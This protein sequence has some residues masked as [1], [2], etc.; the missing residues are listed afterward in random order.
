M[1]AVIVLIVLIVVIVVIVLFVA[2]YA[3]RE[4]LVGSGHAKMTVTPCTVIQYTDRVARFNHE[5]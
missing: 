4:W 3:G 1:F 2:L 5:H